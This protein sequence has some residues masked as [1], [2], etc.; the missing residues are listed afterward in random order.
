MSFRGVFLELESFQMRTIS[1]C[2]Y[3]NNN[4][5]DDDDDDSDG[6]VDR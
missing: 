3:N 2:G 1:D 6:D 5:D 4:D